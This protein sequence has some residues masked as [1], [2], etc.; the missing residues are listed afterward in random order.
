MRS[1]LHGAARIARVSAPFILVLSVLFTTAAVGAAQ[2]I[3]R[4]NTGAEYTGSLTGL[5]PVIRLNVPPGTTFVGPAQAFDIPLSSITQITVDFPRV[6]VE[7]PARV[8][9]GP[10]SAYAGI[11]QEIA[12][13]GMYDDY[14]VDFSAI[15]AISLKGEAIHP[16]PHAWLG[17]QFL[18]ISL[19]PKPM[20]GTAPAAI[21]TA[22]TE[23]TI[24]TPSGETTDAQ[25]W[26][27]LY[28]PTTE[29][30]TTT[31]ATPWWIGLIVVAALAVVV[32]FFM[33]R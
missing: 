23:G 5:A 8:Y 26:A 29:E 20:I 11:D 10:Y 14:T 15:R 28:P 24:A 18:V 33:N 12:I 32:Y 25:S 31:E 3:V 22:S 21:E 9:V 16:V 7:T 2:P 19:Q 1:A 17:D 13:H 27:D 6:V 30:Q 4:T